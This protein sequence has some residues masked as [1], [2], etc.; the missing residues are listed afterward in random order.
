MSLLDSNTK[1]LHCKIVY[2]GPSLGG[3]TTNLQCIAE[4]LNPQGARPME[5]GE[6]NERTELFDLF[7][8]SVGVIRG[9]QTRFHLITVPGQLIH[10]SRRKLIIKGIDGV[11]FVADSQRE[12]MEENLQSLRELET[13]LKKE[14]YDIAE[15]PL[16]VQYNKRDLPNA[17]PISEMRTLLNKYNAPDFEAVAAKGVGVMES[18][19][20][21]SKLVITILKGGEV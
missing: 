15:I 17:V 8:I 19:K 16:I 9:Y 20:A 12:R 3:K 10:D 5:F 13:N 14:G 2:Y 4:E 18:F 11:V 21:I 6:E 7:P 1:Q